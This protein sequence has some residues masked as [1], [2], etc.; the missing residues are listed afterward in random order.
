M[1]HPLASPAPDLTGQT[2]EQRLRTSAEEL[3]K[4]GHL[5]TD[6]FYRINNQIDAAKH[7]QENDHG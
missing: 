2:V 1:I 4:H 6:E 7:V 5:K 3:R